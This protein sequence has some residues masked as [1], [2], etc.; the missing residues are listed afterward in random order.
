[1]ADAEEAQGFREDVNRLLFAR[2]HL[3]TCHIGTEL[4][5]ETTTGAVFR[6][7]LFLHRETSALVRGML[8]HKTKGLLLL[9]VSAM[10]RDE[11][12]SNGR[13]KGED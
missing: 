7:G 2:M 6:I 4:F 12:D 8:T 1:M 5:L 9:L 13:P 11:G 3:Q 10:K